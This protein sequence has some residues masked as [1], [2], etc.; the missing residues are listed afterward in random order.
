M[1]KLAAALVASADYNSITPDNLHRNTVLEAGGAVQLPHR[2]GLEADCRGGSLGI[3]ASGRSVRTVTAPE[4]APC[5]DPKEVQLLYA[6]EVYWPVAA[7]ERSQRRL[8]HDPPLAKRFT[9]AA[10]K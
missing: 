10:R 1:R 7:V 4:A 2:H 8:P 3:N 9:R 5:A 6:R